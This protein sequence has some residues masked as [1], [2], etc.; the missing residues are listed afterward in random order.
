MAYLVKILFVDDLDSPCGS[1]STTLD[2]VVRQGSSELDRGKTAST[3]SMRLKTQLYARYTYVP[4]VIPN[5]Y[6][7]VQSS[8]LLKKGIGYYCKTPSP[9]EGVAVSFLQP[10][11]R[12]FM[13]SSKAFQPANGTQPHPIRDD[14]FRAA[15]TRNYCT[16]EISSFRQTLSTHN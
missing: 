12:S 2:S 3:V 1:F 8:V 9:R 5:L 7:F 16:T 4:N 13:F 11:D 6:F 10:I 15:K 14:R